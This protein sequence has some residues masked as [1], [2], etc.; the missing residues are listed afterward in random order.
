[1][2]ALRLGIAVFFPVLS[3]MFLGGCG[4]ETAATVAPSVI[5]TVPVA[6]A[7]GVPVNQ[8][9][10]ATFN[11]PMNPSTITASTFVLTGP[12][13]NAVTGTVTY[14]ASGSVA[15]FAPTAMLAFNTT[16]TATITT[17]VA[18]T[19]GVHPAA[20]YTWSFTTLAQPIVPVIQPIVTMTLPTSG[21]A[22]VPVTQLLSAAFS[23]IM[24]SAT[25][26]NTTFFL[27]GPGATAV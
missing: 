1:M 13:A 4:K 12:G 15:S 5:S 18:N 24:N 22:G 3:V 6:G 8:V 2:R 14:A 7:T 20:G 9:V 17:T 16:Y 23:K 19:L 26:N 10:S 11:E 21:A 25:I 27:T